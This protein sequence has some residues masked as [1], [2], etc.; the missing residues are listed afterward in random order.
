[1]WFFRTIGA[2][3]LGSAIAIHATAQQQAAAPVP[4][5][6]HGVVVD[7]GVPLRGTNVFD[8]ETLEGTVTAADGRFAIPVRDTSRHAIRIG[9]RRVG[10]KPADVVAVN[11]DSLIVTLEPL[12]ALPAVSVHAGR[13][14]ASAERTATLTPLEVMTTPGGGDV[15]ST[16]KTL[17]GV[18]NVD[19]GSGLFIRGGDYTE[20]RTFIEGA[21]MFT[22]Y[23]FEA[24]TGSVAGTINPFLTDG[25]SYS[26]GGFGVEFGNA[27]SGVVDLRT[28]GR[29]QTTSLSTSATL[30]SVGAGGGLRLPHGFGLSATA[31]LSDLSSFF[32]LNGN[33]RG[34]QPAPR[35]NTESLQAVWEYS[36]AGRLKFFALR[37]ESAMGILVDDPSYS[38]VF[39]NTRR[40]DIVV[41]SLRDTIA[42]WRPFVG[43]STSGLARHDTNTVYDARSTLRSWQARAEAEY[44]WSPRAI[45]LVGA[46]VERIA[47]DYSTRVPRD[48]YDE[49]PDANAA[50]SSLDR[51][52]SRTAIYS[53][54]DAWPLASVEMV[55][56]IRSDRSAYATRATV[57]PRV[58]STWHV[59]GP[60]SII[61]SIGVYHQVADPAFLEQSAPNGTLPSLAATMAIA[62]AQLGD[63]S[64][65]VRVEAWRKRY[66]DLVDLT[67]SFVAVPSLTGRAAGADLFA[68]TDGPLGTHLRLTWSASRSRRQDPDTKLDA[69]A[70]FDISTSITAVIE[71]DWANG[72]HVGIADRLATGRPFTDVVSAALDSARNVYVPTY[73]APFADRLPEYRRIDIAVS[74]AM[75]LDGGRFLALFGA[76]QNPLNT[77]N[78]FGYTWTRDYA[79]R[80][81]MR[82]AIN[83]TVFVGANLVLSRNP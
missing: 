38:S 68:R 6:I 70:R 20:T 18:Q 71:R 40:S 35:G 76:L 27:L 64:R 81:A 80:V 77:K 7:R 39:R 24:P 59:R 83:R 75:V 54:M 15:N 16:V 66:R 50:R 32:A 34:Y 74:R 14:T 58:S 37:Q 56:G 31:S 46:E 19:E 12:A 33:P 30:L 82:S 44:V 60:L 73:G 49:S 78:L 61:G 41:V 23:Q 79:E 5:T 65:F 42:A 53:E 11:D 10:Y 52:G 57:D 26:A 62:G 55:A 13:F 28:Q 3:A 43:V 1:M 47:A 17:P 36:S 67:R 21:P 45:G 48:A 4:R 29:P 8:K 2:V 51:V 72:W 69:P 22:P 63:G 9:A 25:I